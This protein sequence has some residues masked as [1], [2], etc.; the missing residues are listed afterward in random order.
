MLEFLAPPLREAIRY[1]NVNLLYEL[2][3]RAG[4]PVVCDLGGR[5]VFLGEHGAT[6]RKEDALVCSYAEIGGMVDR[7]SEFSV[8]SV[9]EQMKQGF[10]TGAC[11][12]RVGLAGAFVYENGVPSAIREITSLNVRIPHEV[13]GAA[14][15]LFSERFSKGI[16]SCMIL[17]PPGRG[18]TTILRDLIR[19]IAQKYRINI[20]LDDE[21]NEI[22]AVYKDFSLDIGPF[23]DVL[24]YAC[25]RDAAA[26]AVR[27]M[28]PDLIVM[29]ELFGEEEVEVCAACIR[30]GVRVIASAHCADFAGFCAVPA[31]ARALR[32]RLFDSYTELAADGIGKVAHIYDAGARCVYGA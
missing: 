23:C 31:F 32:D 13:K 21:R 11:G 16:E 29:D 3:L 18:K 7:L 19:L 8:Y 26:V 12:E 27:A 25:K 2:R 10:L 20:L 22:A 9:A 4:C 15:L 30:S 1:V 6:E 17:S 5:Y 24:R 14:A 28:R